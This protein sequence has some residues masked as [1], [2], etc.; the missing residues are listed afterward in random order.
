MF[1]ALYKEG[2]RYKKAG[3]IVTD[4]IPDNERPINLF[5]KDIEQKHIPVMNV[6]DF[7]NRKYGKT[8]S[9]WLPKAENPPTKGKTYRRNM[10]NS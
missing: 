10:K 8:K 5:E 1:E 6:M 9:V 4:L 3:V 7:L 2:F